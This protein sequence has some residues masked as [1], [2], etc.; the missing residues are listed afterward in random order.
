MTGRR[1]RRQNQRGIAFFGDADQCGWP[2]EA[3]NEAFRDQQAFI[4]RAG[5]RGD[6]DLA[7]SGA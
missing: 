6:L 1:M 5:Y 7:A 3:F 4:E 2:A